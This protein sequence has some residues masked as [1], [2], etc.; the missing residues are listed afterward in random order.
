MPGADFHESVERL[1]ERFQARWV[2]SRLRFI[3]VYGLINGMFCLLLFLLMLNRQVSMDLSAAETRI[4]V[5]EDEQERSPTVAPTFQT[6][7]S[8]ATATPVPSGATS[9]AATRPSQQ[10]TVT[11]PPAKPP[12][13]TF[14][15]TATQPPTVTPTPTLTAT[16]T[17]TP[18]DTPV[19]TFTATSSPTFTN[20]PS[21]VPTATP[22][23][24][25]T[26][27]PKP[28]ETATRRPT[29]T[30]TPLPPPTRPSPAPTRPSQGDRPDT[31]GE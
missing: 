19:P 6:T 2:G 20:T 10:A 31:G 30:P 28:T 1:V 29:K 21:L 4:V 9:T 23:A 13:P 14:T 22:T 15:A 16:V 27:T 18:T 8:E 24:T 7:G 3:L 17:R 12:A 25:W 5:L 11:L 26:N